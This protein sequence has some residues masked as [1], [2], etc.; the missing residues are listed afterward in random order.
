MKP[1][2]DGRGRVFCMVR[3]RWVALTPEE[4]VRQATIAMLHGDY[5]Y[6]LELMQVEGG[7][8]VGGLKRR[9]DIVVFDTT[10]SPT[11]IVECKR[12]GVP[13]TQEVCD[14]ACRYNSALR[15]PHLLL[16][17]G[18]QMVVVGVDFAGKKIV[19]L[20]DIPFFHKKS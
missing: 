15:V 7:I 14:Q 4:E 6:P 12:R 13:I 3:R 18:E 5:G 10:G 17:N 16:T 19:Q 8:S 11:L 20:P 9:C 2:G 1:T